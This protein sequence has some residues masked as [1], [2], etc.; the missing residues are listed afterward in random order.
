MGKLTLLTELD[1]SQNA[2]TGTFPPELGALSSLSYLCGALHAQRRVADVCLRVCVCVCVC[3][4]MSLY[5]WLCVCVF[6]SVHACVWWHRDLSDNL[7]TGALPDTVGG[8][9]NLMGL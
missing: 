5:V 4:C 7:L 1:L 8:F 2:L 3:V 9:G 6:V